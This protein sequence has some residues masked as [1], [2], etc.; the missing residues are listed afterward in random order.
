MG[1]ENGNYNG[2]INMDNIKIK[3]KVERVLLLIRGAQIL[4]RDKSF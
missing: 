1:I 3:I 4:A 2:I